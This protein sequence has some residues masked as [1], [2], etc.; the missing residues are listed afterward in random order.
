MS[1]IQAL[2]GAQSG[3]LNRRPTLRFQNFRRATRSA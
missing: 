1:S 2:Y 3:R